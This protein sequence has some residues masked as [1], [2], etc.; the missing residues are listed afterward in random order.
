MVALAD[1]WKKAY[2]EPV[3]SVVVERDDEGHKVA[4]ESKRAR[5][6]AARLASR[7]NG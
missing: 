1:V 4:A 2:V 7:A 6:A 5:R 3:K